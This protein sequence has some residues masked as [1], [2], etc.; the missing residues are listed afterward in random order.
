M[1][2]C[3]MAPWG[4]LQKNCSSLEKWQVFEIQIMPLSNRWPPKCLHVLTITSITLLSTPISST[5]CL[6]VW[7][8]HKKC[9]KNRLNGN[10]KGKK[11]NIPTNIISMRFPKNIWHLLTSSSSF[12]LNHTGFSRILR[13]LYGARPIFPF[14]GHYFWQILVAFSILYNP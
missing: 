14:W 3:G 5:C 13:V 8:L 10:F 6:V 1:S 2:P 7:D 11:A 12:L 9:K 4:K